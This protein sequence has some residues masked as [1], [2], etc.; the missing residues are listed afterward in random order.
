MVHL[1]Q[2]VAG[3]PLKRGRVGGV[4]GRAAQRAEFGRSG[5]DCY[6]MPRGRVPGRPVGTAFLTSSPRSVERN[7]GSG[8][9]W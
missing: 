7:P 3:E 5:Q 6:S 9:G 4:E 1:F 8:A 2:Q